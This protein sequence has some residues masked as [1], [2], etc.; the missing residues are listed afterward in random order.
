MESNV[1]RGL[2]QNW[3]ESGDLRMRDAWLATAELCD[4]LDEIGMALVR[5]EDLL[6]HWS[7]KK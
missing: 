1:M 6:G 2:A 4:R 5:L 7:M 3:S